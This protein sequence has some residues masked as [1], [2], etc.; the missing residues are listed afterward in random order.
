MVKVASFGNLETFII[1]A[2]LV[3]FTR[4]GYQGKVS[5]TGKKIPAQLDA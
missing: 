1:L 2:A 5:R 4:E 3:T